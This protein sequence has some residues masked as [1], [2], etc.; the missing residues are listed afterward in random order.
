MTPGRARLLAEARELNPHIPVYLTGRKKLPVHAARLHRLWRGERSG[1]LRRRRRRAVGAACRARW[2]GLSPD[3]GTQRQ[4]PEPDVRAVRRVSRG[5]AYSPR[6]RVPTAQRRRRCVTAAAGAR[7]RIPC[8]EHVAAAWPAVAPGAGAAP[9]PR[10]GRRR[11]PRPARSRAPRVAAPTPRRSVGCRE[12]GAER[13]LE[14]CLG[15]ELERAVVGGVGW[16]RAGDVESSRRDA[17][18]VLGF[19]RASR[20]GGRAVCRRAGASA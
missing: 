20:L 14:R 18:V 17:A 10:G 12:L 8:D 3:R 2:P 4:R 6:D 9:E 15:P 13:P 7:R 19:L 16:L 5:M 1:R 11:V